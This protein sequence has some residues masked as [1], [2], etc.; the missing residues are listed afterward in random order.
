MW[1]F[2]IPILICA[3]A[4]LAL[5]QDAG[6]RLAVE[7]IRGKGPIRD[8]AAFEGAAATKVAL[9]PQ[10]V[11]TPFHMQPSVTEVSVRGVRNRDHAAFLLEWADATPDWRTSIDHFGDAIAIA[12]PMATDPLPSPTMGNPK[13]RVHI[14][15]WRADFQSDVERGAITIRELYPNAYNADLYHEDLVPGDAGKEYAVA[16]KAG[17]PASQRAP[18]SVQELV[19]EGFGSLTPTGATSAQGV[20][21]HDEK[22]WHVVI[23]RPLAGDG[24]KSANLA[25]GSASQ[26]AIAAWDGS[27][28]EV[29]ARKSWFGWLPLEIAK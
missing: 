8:A 20:G 1:R 17:N 21:R 5:G 3:S 12:F 16:K 22:G 27:K 24:V 29:G 7:T 26:L 6:P 25:P 14:L 15:Q 10:V 23:S 4:A 9:L 2:L 19:A 13:G 18:S 28:G 11:T